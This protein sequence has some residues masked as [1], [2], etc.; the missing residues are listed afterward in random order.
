VH[1]KVGDIFVIPEAKI[2]KENMLIPG[3]D[4][5]KMSKSKGNVI[6]I[7]QTDKALRK[8]IMS[9]QTDSTAL[10]AP[11]DWS[12]CNSFAIY[13]LLAS[14]SQVAEMKQNYEA[15]G[16]GYGHAKQALFE[17]I[18]EQFSE[19]RERYA[20]YMENLEEVDQAL[21]IG[22]EKAAKTANAVLQRV[23]EKIGY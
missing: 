23:R 10:E 8:Q 6:D 15:V 14:D 18:C 12:T 4:G 7:F 20:Y 2:Q 21:E 13:K 19:Q 9:I 1:A 16:Y 3:T 17:L 11:K 22:A 5:Q